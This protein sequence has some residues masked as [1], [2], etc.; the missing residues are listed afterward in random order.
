MIP[1]IHNLVI[2]SLNSMANTNLKREESKTS[3]PHD[4][5]MQKILAVS[6]ANKKAHPESH[7]EQEKH[8]AVKDKQTTRHS[9]WVPFVCLLFFL[10]AF[11]PRIYFIYG[12]SNPDNPGAGWFGDA[13]HHWQIAYLTK[14]IGLNQGFLRLWDLKG[15]EFFWGL[16]HPI[17]IMTAFAITGDISVGM[18]RAVTALFGSFSVVLIFLLLRKHWNTQTAIAGALFAAL[19]PVGVFNDG[20]G[21]VEPLGIPFLLLGVYLWPSVSWLAGIS[22]G[23]AVMARGEYWLMAFGL[24]FAMLLFTKVSSGRKL[25]LS[26]GFFGTTLIYMKYLLSWTS[27]PIYPFYQ[28]FLANYVG[29]WQFKEV[30]EPQ[31]IQ[32]KYIFLTIFIITVL[33]SLFLIWKRPRGMFVYL[34]GLGNWMFLGAVFGLG[35]YIKSYMT[36]V[37]YV[38]FMIL[39][40]IFVGIVLAVALFYY[41]PKIRYAKILAKLQ[42]NWLIFLGIL[43]VSQYLWVF[44]WNKYETTEKTWQNSAKYAHG[45][46]EH[47]KGGGLLLFEGN[48]EITY[49]LVRFDHIEGKNITGEMFDPYFYIS[50]DPYRNWNKN[51]KVVLAWIKKNNIRTIATYAQYVRYKQLVQHEPQFFYEDGIVPNTNFVIYQVKD[52]L[53]QTNF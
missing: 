24:V 3:H 20:T 8:D 15:M 5:W 49:A 26:V 7:D 23:I 16:L 10:L 47:Y 40:Y 35:A 45:I 53:Y 2:I 44:I 11:I 46:A 30:L 22:L 29:T 14:E 25:G 21:M 42:F 4:E 19:N 27:N 52:E 36:Y 38:R 17:L 12:V 41:L 31:D 33:W 18:E 37:W 1:D 28:N 9:K 6:E 32:A 51:R 50:G 13:Y 39:P 34:L 43:L 48:P